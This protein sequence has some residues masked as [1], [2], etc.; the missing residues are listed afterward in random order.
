MQLEKSYSF[1][2]DHVVCL[3]LDRAAKTV[4]Y[5]DP[6]GTPLERQSRR[7]IGTN[8]PANQFIQ[9]LT[10]EFDLIHQYDFHNCGVHI[11]WYLEARQMGKSF[12]E[13]TASS[14]VSPL[15]FRQHMINQLKNH[16]L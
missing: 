6:H 10:K 9:E 5:Y 16:A 2:R 14:G 12:Q 3:T 8:L 11:C 13:I 1:S 15:S 7:V 4:E